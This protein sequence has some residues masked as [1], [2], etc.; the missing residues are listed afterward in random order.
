MNWIK[1]VSVILVL[2]LTTACTETQENKVRLDTQ[3]D[4]KPVENKSTPSKPANKT[5]TML[6]EGEETPIELKLYEEQNLFSTYFPPEDFVVESQTLQQQKAVKF[7][8]NF[9]GVKNEN[10][11]LQLI[12]PENAEN[13]EAI[14]NLI[15]GENGLLASNQWQIVQRDHNV[16]Y[17]WVKEKIA[18]SKGQDIVGDI[19]IGEE[20]GKVFY[21]ITHLPIEYVDGFAAREKLILNDLEIDN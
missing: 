11:Y 15:T 13:I 18:F 17:P 20:N 7:V 21:V 5:A 8:V 4:V 2:S 10:A 12:F 19:Y 1:I 3:E 6:I 14:K 16:P 9:G